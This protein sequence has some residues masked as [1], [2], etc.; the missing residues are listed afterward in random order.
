MRFTTTATGAQ[1]TAHRH[2]T[3]NVTAMATHPTAS[4]AA[5]RALTRS[6][7]LDGTASGE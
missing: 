5:P 6:S 2:M 4:R 3:A 7:Q 1:T